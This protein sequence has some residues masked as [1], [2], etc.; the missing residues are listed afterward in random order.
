[1]TEQLELINQTIFLWINAGP[2]HGGLS[3]LVTMMVAE[4]LIYLVPLALVWLWLRGDPDERAGLFGATLA[5][6]LALFINQIIAAIWY[7]PRPFVIPLGQLLIPH[8]PD[9]SFPSDHVTFIGAIAFGLLVFSRY[10]KLA[11]GFIATAV[12]IGW[13]RIYAGVH[14]PFDILAGF[15]SA[16]LGVLFAVPF[17]SWIRNTLMNGLCLPLY[18]AIFAWPIARG[19]VLP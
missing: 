13:S 17:A 19:W 9:S 6:M 3:D 1:M 5:A 12:L 4:Y 18:R 2:D 15:M 16:L 14:F 7:H 11:L 10:H 8:A